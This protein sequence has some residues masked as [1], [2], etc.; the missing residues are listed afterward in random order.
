MYILLVGDERFTAPGWTP[1][2]RAP[3]RALRAE[4]GCDVLG[5]SLPADRRETRRRL[6]TGMWQVTGLL[7]AYG[8][9]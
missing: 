6:A 3:S 7:T 8:S 5:R 4:H 2:T 9:P 1:P